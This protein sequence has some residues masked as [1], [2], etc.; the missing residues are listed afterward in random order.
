MSG[1][2][3]DDELAKIREDLYELL[4]GTAIIQRPSAGTGLYGS[5][6]PSWNNVGTVVCRVDSIS[7]QDAQGIIADA[8]VGKTYYQMTLPY[9][10]DL[11]DGDRLSIG[12]R[13]YECLQIFRG[14]SANG[15]RRAVLATKDEGN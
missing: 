6:A 4:P 14:Q 13:V 3:T 12:G 2:L 8:E 5:H 15:V 1:F 7:R 10:G 9:N 11:R